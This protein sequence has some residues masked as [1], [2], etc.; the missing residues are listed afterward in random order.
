[1]P[2]G[3]G[4]DDVEHCVRLDSDRAFP[5]RVIHSESP[6]LVT[7]WAYR[8]GGEMADA[9]CSGREAVVAGTRYRVVFT[10]NAVS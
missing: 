3:P 8:I 1:M 10:R 2:V 9:A 6:S 5:W 7:N 4:V